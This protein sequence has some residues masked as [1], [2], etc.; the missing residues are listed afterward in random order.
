M[1]DAEREGLSERGLSDLLNKAVAEA[2]ECGEGWWWLSFADGG[3]PTGQQFLGVA[4]VRAAGLGFAVM[5]AHA[6]G[7]NPGGE[8]QGMEIPAACAPPDAMLDHLTTDPARI[9]ELE[10]QWCEASWAAIGKPRPA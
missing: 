8:V 6:L 10:E 7:I 2:V 5:R 9:A 3:R 4:V 1:S